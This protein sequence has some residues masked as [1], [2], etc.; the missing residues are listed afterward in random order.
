MPGQHAGKVAAVTGAGGGL[1]RAVAVTLARGGARVAC[2]DLNGDAVQETVD[3][4][5]NAGGVAVAY[6]VD[7]TSE[8]SLL[9]WRDAIHA[10]LGEVSILANVAGVLDRRL[11]VDV[12]LESF[13]KV[14]KV[15][16]GGTYACTRTFSADL[17]TGGWGRVVNVGSIAG[18]TG[19]PYPSYASSKAG[20]VNLTRSLLVELWGT[21][22]T[23]NAVCPGAM[24]TPMLHREALDLML[25][26]TPA[27]RIVTPDE[28]A[29]LVDFLCTDAA[30]CINGAAVVIDGGATAIFRY[31]E[32]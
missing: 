12:D 20:V 21:G 26:R 31:F 5:A 30:D 32:D 23:V 19:Y 29:G 11:M 17:R 25:K 4:V 22:V 15:N 8:Q 16:L 1:G 14:L 13:M 6:E 24:D 3:L 9:G 2:S 27:N 18:V 28:V 10:E 7:V